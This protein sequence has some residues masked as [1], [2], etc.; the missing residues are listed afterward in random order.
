[1]KKIYVFLVM[2]LLIFVIAGCG[3]SNNTDDQKYTELIQGYEVEFKT[4]DNYL[5]WKY[6]NESDSNWRILYNLLSLKGDTGAQGPQGEQ[7]IQG[8]QGEQGIQGL[9]GEQGIQG[10]AG[11]NGSNGKSAYEI[12]KENYPE[13]TG[14]EKEW[15][16]AI[17]KND[18]CALFG[19][20]WDEGV[21]TTDAQV[22]VNGEITYTC[23]T[24]GEHKYEVIP[25]IVPLDL[26]IYTEDEISYINFGK[27]PQSH[28]SDETII[29]ALN[30]L[31]ETNEDGYYEYNGHEYAKIKAT[32][33]SDCYGCRTYKDNFGETQYVY[34]NY[35]DGY[36]I[37]NNSIEYFLVEPI[38]WRILESN[39]GE[40]IIIT[41]KIIDGSV[42]YNSRYD[43]KIDDEVIYPNN[44]KYS[45]IR[46]YINNDLYN[47]AFNESQ[48]NAIHVT[49][50]DNSATS[51]QSKSNPF[52][53]ENT[54]DK[55]FLLSYKDVCSTYWKGTDE[56]TLRSAN[57]TDYGIA[58]GLFFYAPNYENVTENYYGNSAWWLRSPYDY[59][60]EEANII[61]GSGYII[62]YQDIYRSGVGFMYWG[63]RPACKITI[64]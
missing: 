37:K 51:T 44:Y 63:I 34:Y 24:C 5:M 36:N 35:S 60:K 9:Q 48:K 58:K 61:N 2:I 16:T 27:Y 13:Y 56:N 33:S 28:V 31:T 57:V 23:K 41:D 18:V 30:T 42:Y 15:I 50:V 43:R 21:I 40:Y 11:Q 59:G 10:E 49:E 32:P 46:E 22:G 17:A 25:M 6:K 53:C 54:Y 45:V 19:H 29:N 38:K 12:F 55:M 3:K 47:R 20:E 26:Q 1:M 39:N 52:V 62:P 7:G 14:T 64:Q 8:P 4:A